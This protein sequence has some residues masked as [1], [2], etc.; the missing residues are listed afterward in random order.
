MFTC[1]VIPGTKDQATPQRITLP[2][3]NSVVVMVETWKKICDNFWATSL[4]NNNAF[5]NHL[6]SNTK[7]HLVSA[8]AFA[9]SCW[10]REQDSFRP[11][12]PREVQYW[13]LGPLSQIPGLA[14]ATPSAEILPLRQHPLLCSAWCHAYN[15]SSTNK[16]LQILTTGKKTTGFQT[17]S[18]HFLHKEICP[19][20]DYNWNHWWRHNTTYTVWSEGSEYRWETW[21][22]AQHCRIPAR[23]I[24]TNYSVEIRLL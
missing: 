3:Q 16:C 1:T 13:T 24:Q 19:L 4:K 2:W 12:I 5:R 18:Q 10:L 23:R 7:I 11:L 14:T 8:G 17:C 22:L 20:R 9:T 6:I 21:L 15:R